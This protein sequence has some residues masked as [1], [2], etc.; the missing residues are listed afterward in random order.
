MCNVSWENP[1]LDN[2]CMNGECV[3]DFELRQF[4]CNCYTGYS[5]QICEAT[6][7]CKSKKFNI[8]TII[9]NSYTMN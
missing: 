3:P 7:E 2:P 8:I 1:C 5:G 4:T 9:S 6:L